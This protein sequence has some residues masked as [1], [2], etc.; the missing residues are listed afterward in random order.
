VKHATHVTIEG[1]P[2]FE[3]RCRSE[4]IGIACGVEG[5]LQ[6]R[7]GQVN[8]RV[9]Q[10]PIMLAVP[11]LGGV[12][13]VGAV[14][15]FDLQ[16]EPVDLG[17]ERF[18][19]R[20]EGVLG[21]EGLTCGLEGAVDCKWEIDVAGALPGRMARASVEFVEVEEDVHEEER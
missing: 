14:G 5:S 19:L 7:L 18:E 20:C 9:G 11:F 21:S 3:V 1:A 17:V 8:A 16:L 2:R 4:P 12:Q 6:L 13:A 15:P 10:V